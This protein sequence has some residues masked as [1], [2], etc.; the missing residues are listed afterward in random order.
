LSDDAKERLNKVDADGEPEIN[1]V[2]VVFAS[3]PDD[4]WCQ[5][6]RRKC[7]CCIR[8]ENTKTGKRWWKLRCKMFAMVEHKYFET[9][10]IIM[11][12]A[13]SLALVSIGFVACN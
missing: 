12:M 2:D 1:E 7:P 10:I 3:Y 4:C 11:I 9:F 13:S 6:F 8:M 5:I